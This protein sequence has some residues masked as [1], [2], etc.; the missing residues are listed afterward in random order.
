METET[1][2]YEDAH[3]LGEVVTRGLRYRMYYDADHGAVIFVLI[4]G[5]SVHA[6]DAAAI[7]N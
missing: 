7:L 4:P 1:A 2:F 5:Q 3:E 6:S